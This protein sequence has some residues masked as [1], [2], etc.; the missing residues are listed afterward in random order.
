MPSAWASFNE[1]RFAST[2]HDLSA[3]W[4]SGADDAWAVGDGVI[5]KWNG[6]TWSLT[7]IPT[8][9]NLPYTTVSGMVALSPGIVH[10]VGIT[11][12]P[13]TTGDSRPIALRTSNG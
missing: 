9:G 7:A 5:L 8:S 10:A 1:A 6:S 13:I 3:V 2:T 12:D 4:G 11:S